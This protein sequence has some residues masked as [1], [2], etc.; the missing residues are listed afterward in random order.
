MATDEEACS[1]PFPD[2]GMATICDRNFQGAIETLSE[3]EKEIAKLH[4]QIQEV[5]KSMYNTN[6]VI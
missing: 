5:L 1:S 3:R 2:D 6:R 4:G